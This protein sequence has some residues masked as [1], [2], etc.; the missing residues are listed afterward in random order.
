MKLDFILRDSEFIELNN[1]LK[2]TGLCE[3]GGRAN[4]LITAGQVKV[5]GKVELRKRRKIRKGQNIELSGTMITV[6]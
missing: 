1:V 4:R 3:S 5:D 2:V 6:K